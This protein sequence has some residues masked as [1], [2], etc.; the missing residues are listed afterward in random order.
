MQQMAIRESKITKQTGEEV[1]PELG[2]KHPVWL[3]LEFVTL[4]CPEGCRGA[5]D[6]GSG[7]FPSRNTSK[8]KIGSGLASEYPGHWPLMSSFR[9]VA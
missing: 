6:K 9:N 8:D 2:R 3:F 7:N 4:M 5:C 1:A